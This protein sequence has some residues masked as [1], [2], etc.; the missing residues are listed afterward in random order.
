MVQTAFK[1]WAVIVEALGQ[2]EQI[3]ILRKGGIAEGKGG[4]RAEHERFWLFPTR[5][6]QQTEGVVPEAAARFGTMT[7]PPE[8]VLRIQYAAEVVEARRLESFTTAKRLAG[9]HIWRDDVI[10][11]RFDWGR[12]QGIYAMAVRVRQFAA[13]MDLPML[14]EYGGCKSW[15]ELEPAMD[16]TSTKPVLEVAV[17]EQKLAEFREALV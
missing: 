8:D 1:E 16:F 4:F 10:A 17:F 14:E 6:H 5:F 3:V 7:F 2:G 9:Q 13:P 11:E 12:D 15:I